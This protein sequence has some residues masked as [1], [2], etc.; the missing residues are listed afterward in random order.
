MLL[1]GHL[2]TYVEITD[3]IGLQDKLALKDIQTL[4]LHHSCIPT[5]FFKSIVINVD[6]MLMQYGPLLYH[7]MEEAR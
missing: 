6:V 3:C 4:D 7:Q 1:W 2:L 5:N